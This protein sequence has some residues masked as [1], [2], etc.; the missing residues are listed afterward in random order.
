MDDDLQPDGQQDAPQEKSHIKELAA[1]LLLAMLNFRREYLLLIFS[2]HSPHSPADDHPHIPTLPF[3]S[4]KQSADDMARRM[5]DE[6]G[7]TVLKRSA[8]AVAKALQDGTDP[9]DAID[10]V[11]HSDQLLDVWSE[12]GSTGALGQAAEDAGAQLDL[13]LTWTTRRDD[14]VRDTHRLMD[15]QVRRAGQYFESPSGATTLYP[16]GFGVMS[17]DA[18]CRCQL[19]P[20]GHD[21]G[22]AWEH[23]DTVRQKVADDLRSQIGESMQAYMEE[24]RKMTELQSMRFDLSA[25]AIALPDEEHP[26]RLPFTGVLTKVDEPSDNPPG[27]SNGKRVIIPKAVAEQALDSLAA[28]GVD[29]QDDFSGHDPTKK[30]GVI[31]AAEIGGNDL[32]IGGFFYVSDFPEE[33]AFI[34]KNKDKLGFSYEA[35]VL[36]EDT[37]ANPIKVTQCV[38]TGAAVLLKDKAAYTTTSISASAE[39]GQQ[40]TKEEM[41]ALFAEAVAPIAKQLEDVTKEVTAIK[42]SA[43]TLQAGS[44]HHL[45]APHVSDIRAC[46]D[47]LE[48]A[49]FGS[50]P[51]TGHVAVLRS[52]ADKME[53][54]SHNGK[55]PTQYS[56]S[57]YA[58]A[59]QGQIAVNPKVAELEKTV[60]ELST[61]LDASA[62]DAAALKASA[63]HNSA[64]PERKTMPPAVMDLLRKGGI[65]LEAGAE[66]LTA[67]QVDAV[68]KAS[69][70]NDISSRMATKTQL[71]AAGLMQ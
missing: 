16:G 55:L 30:I 37:N 3:D 45:V 62:A 2:P 35:Q 38:F 39:E 20:A 18:L 59:E 48:A 28:M 34:Q 9:D 33:V 29:Y 23:F 60:A 49:G 65:T 36:I 44:V 67:E 1:A 27:G 5:T 13:D 63:A 41:Q 11:I 8:R 69:G 64:A 43:A 70:K 25:M 42:E 40:M 31:T 10:K 22:A 7:K 32:K 56:D 54:D 66:Q 15:G 21:R 71:R 19:V 14:R 52:M 4:L 17:E 12:W 57:Y 24:A 58:S 26:N 53:S 46:A 51:K 68:L 6:I 50:V 61:K 47:K